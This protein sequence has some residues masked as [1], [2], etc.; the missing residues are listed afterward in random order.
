[1]TKSLKTRYAE[2]ARRAF[3]SSRCLA[4][5][6]FETSC[7]AAGSADTITSATGRS[8]DEA[9]LLPPL[10]LRTRNAYIPVLESEAAASQVT[11]GQASD[12]D[13]ILGAVDYSR[14]LVST[15]TPARH[16]LVY[17]DEACVRLANGDQL[18]AVY[19]PYD[20][21]RDEALGINEQS[22][23]TSVLPEFSGHAIQRVNALNE[24]QAAFGLAIRDLAKILN[25]S[26]PQIYRW[27][28][29]SDQVRLSAKSLNRLEEI[30]S[31]A[32]TWK[33]QSKTPLGS[34]SKDPGSFVREAIA[35]MSQEKIDPS[36]IKKTLVRQAE[37]LKD[38]PRTLSSKLRDRG[39]A[40]R[41][42]AQFR[43][44]DE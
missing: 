14:G 21:S 25:L 8:I 4:H 23:A 44:D 18:I 6:S 39:I 10:V 40:P 11:A 27:L 43:D 29:P 20:S 34:A 35:L 38:R 12:F 37:Y 32:K 3:L 41:S 26:P 17:A 28:D 5:I 1:M 30:G 16:L 24:I 33:V 42:R 7:R 13:L 31:L 22:L 15:A 2:E 9:A 19:E 36:K